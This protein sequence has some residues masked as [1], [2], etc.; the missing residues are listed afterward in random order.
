[1]RCIQIV[2]FFASFQ[3]KIYSFSK[4]DQVATDLPVSLPDG[5]E[6]WDDA[7]P[8]GLSHSCTLLQ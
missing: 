7:S 3:S 8:V 2:H 6:Q 4:E 5:A 1:M